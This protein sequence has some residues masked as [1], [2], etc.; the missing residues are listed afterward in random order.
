MSYGDHFD[1]S[2][3]MYSNNEDRTKYKGPLDLLFE[4][5]PNKRVGSPQPSP[6]P[7]QPRAAPPLPSGDQPLV[8]AEASGDEPRVEAEASGDQPRVEAEA[9]VVQ[10][11]DDK[12][13]PWKDL[14]KFGNN[15]VATFIF[16]HGPRQFWH[17]KSD[18]CN[19][20]FL[21]RTEAPYVEA[22][23][24]LL[25]QW[26]GG[27]CGQ[28]SSMTA[29]SVTMPLTVS[30]ST[31][32]IYDGECQSFESAWKKALRSHSNLK[33]WAFYKV[34]GAVDMDSVDKKLTLSTLHQCAL[35]PKADSFV[36]MLELV[37]DGLLLKNKAKL[38]VTWRVKTFV[39]RRAEPPSLL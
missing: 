9:S 6:K 12:A 5:S 36:K 11:D 19:R 37:R 13:T 27:Y 26:P 30:A 2:K 31:L 22:N 32:I 18:L 24:T 1:F 21:L 4:N 3:P 17:I 38:I 8:E 23:H 29:G 35:K 28:S 15:A 25:A 10:G 20:L 39:S 34:A 16:E 33:I 7:K 14:S